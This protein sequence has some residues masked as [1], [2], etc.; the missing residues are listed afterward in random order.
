MSKRAG[1]ESRERADRAVFVV[2]S[3]LP[4][5]VPYTF[6]Y[7]CAQL[8][9]EGTERCG[10]E[11][12][13][14]EWLH[15]VLSY[16]RESQTAI[17]DSSPRIQRPDITGETDRRYLFFFFRSACTMHLAANTWEAAFSPPHVSTVTLTIG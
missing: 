6:V 10:K 8:A 15:H 12:H 17:R 4:M 5:L 9:R 3:R 13:L 16:E 2:P 14:E 1:F 7:A 11:T